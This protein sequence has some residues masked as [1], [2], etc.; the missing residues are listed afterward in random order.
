MADF[1][2]DLNA[3]HDDLAGSGLLA[4]PAFAHATI[5]CS[6]ARYRVA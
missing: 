3:L 2:G 1:L 4:D 6:P 5:L